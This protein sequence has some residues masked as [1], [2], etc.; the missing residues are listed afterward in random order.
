[1]ATHKK[2]RGGLQVFHGCIIGK[3]EK[4]CLSE[5]AL[6]K[7]RE[8]SQK[9]MCYVAFGMD[10]RRMMNNA[11]Y[12]ALLL[13]RHHWYKAIALKAWCK[14]LWHKVCAYADVYW[15]YLSLRS[16]HTLLCWSATCHIVSHD[17]QTLCW[18]RHSTGN[19]L[20]LW[21]REGVKPH[22]SDTCKCCSLEPSKSNCQRSL[23]SS[24][25]F[26]LSLILVSILSSHLFL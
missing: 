8:T 26:K 16:C 10:G 7:H 9:S 14:Q 1:M 5:L 11:K 20:G 15:T 25:V 24:S 6:G 12:L 2:K 22:G 3:P 21:L 18:N 17:T 19:Q 23:T 13:R 4:A